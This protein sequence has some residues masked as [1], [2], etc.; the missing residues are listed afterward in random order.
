MRTAALALA[1][2]MMA[3]PFA[4]SA[5][6]IAVRPTVAAGN[7]LLTVQ[8]EGRTT[9][10]PDL[11]SFSAGVATAGKTAGEAMAAN[12]AQMSK[13]V[14]ALRRAGIAERDIQTS[15]L[16]LNPVYAPQ[17]PR[18][19]G[20]IEPVEPRIIGYQ[21][22][23]SVTVRQRDLAA[24]GKVIDTLIAAGANQ[25][26]G[27]NFEMDDA[28]AAL[29]QA[30]ADAMKKAR[31]RAQLYATAA[32]LKVVRVVSIAESGGYMPRQAMAYK[33]EAA[34]AGA[35]TPVLAG[36]VALQASVTVQYELAP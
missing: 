8:A 26:N 19:D 17:Q 20:T 25:V 16:N 15:N 24:F 4:A 29:D 36:E 35:D 33:L 12:A 14:A 6:E 32:G 10:R 28:D 3:V 22:N 1:A 23:N 7:T 9:R 11:A 18:P 27:P 5:Q 21:A 13:V 31:A 30:R 34:P 2:T